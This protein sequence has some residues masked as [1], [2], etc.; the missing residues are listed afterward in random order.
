M[1]GIPKQIIQLL[2]G[3]ERLEQ[4]PLEDLKD[5]LDEYPSFNAGHLLLSKKLKMEGLDEFS[6]QTQRTALHFTNPFWLQ[7]LLEKE[8]NGSP[9]VDQALEV[10]TEKLKSEEE[11]VS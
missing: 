3:R 2:F 1:A 7:F 9:Q 4:I 5:L 8:A 10:P 11:P 6:H